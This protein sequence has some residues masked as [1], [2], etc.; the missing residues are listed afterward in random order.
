[1]TTT[2]QGVLRGSRR[3]KVTGGEVFKVQHVETYLVLSDDGTDD[4]ENVYLTSG[5]PQ[6][7]DYWQGQNGNTDFAFVVGLTIMDVDESRRKWEVEVEYSTELPEGNGFQNAGTD[8]IQWTPEIEWD[9]EFI[10]YHPFYDVNGDEIVNGAGDAFTEPPITSLYPIPVFRYSR[11]MS[12]F[13]SAIQHTYAA[14]T[15][16]DVF[17]GYNPGNALMSGVKARPE[18]IYGFQYWWVSYV[19]K[20]RLDGWEGRSRN[21][22]PSFLD[23]GEKKSALTELGRPIT[24]LTTSGTAVDGAGAVVSKEI[25]DSVP[26]GPIL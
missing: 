18:F 4:E 26:F 11:W 1:M 19:V 20:F 3:A 8:P 2:V 14:K 7:G 22:G 6:M 17:L 25:F 21:S 10:E 5:L 9:T 13:T 12:S 15:N 24:G 16:S 23:G